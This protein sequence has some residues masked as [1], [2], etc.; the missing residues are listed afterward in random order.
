MH[1][2]M[3]FPYHEM[4]WKMSCMQSMKT[5]PVWEKWQ[6]T[7]EVEQIWPWSQCTC[8]RTVCMCQS[9]FRLCICQSESLGRAPRHMMGLIDNIGDSD[10]SN[11]FQHH[12]DI[13]NGRNID[14]LGGDSD[15]ESQWQGGDSDR[16]TFSPSE[17]LDQPA[18][19]PQGSPWQVHYHLQQIEYPI[20]LDNRIMIIHRFPSGIWK[21]GDLNFVCPAPEIAWN[22]SQN[23]RKPGE[24]KKLSRKTIKPGMLLKIYISILYW[25]KFFQDLYSC[26]FRMPLV[27]A[28]W[29]QNCLHYNL[30]NDPFDL[31][32]TW[33]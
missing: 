17:S 32:K 25:D 9:L 19:P 1:L 33:R 22:L 23:M 26:D 24:N 29:C 8:L 10:N 4:L 20:S 13:T 6:K 16:Q 21:P 5:L 14:L 11:S 31:D 12:S 30:E 15:S 7:W 27:S 2:S 18:P 28:F 3:A